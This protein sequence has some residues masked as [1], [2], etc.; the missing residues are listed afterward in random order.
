[1]KVGDEY[2]DFETGEKRIADESYVAI[3][4]MLERKDLPKKVI[5]MTNPTGSN[6]LFHMFNQSK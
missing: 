6:F 2:Y 4:K 5:V 1:M 3:N